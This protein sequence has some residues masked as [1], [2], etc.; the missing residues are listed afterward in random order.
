LTDAAS[1]SPLVVELQVIAKVNTTDETSRA[2][3]SIMVSIPL[4]ALVP[5]QLSS[6][7]PPVAVQVVALADVHVRVVDFPAMIVVGDAEI[8]VVT[9]GQ[10]HT[11][12]ADTLTAVTPGAVQLSV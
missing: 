1:D 8:V 6:V 10:F 12:E 4:V 7:P 9:R 3:G 2:K 5:A 11:T